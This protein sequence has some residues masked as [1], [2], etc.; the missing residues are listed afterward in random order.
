MSPET[1]VPAQPRHSGPPLVSV[2]VPA[3]NEEASLGPCLRSITSQGGV[4]FEIIVVDDQSTDATR[5]IA[6]SFA[7]VQ[8]VSTGEL[9]A[10]WSGKCHAVWTGAQRA[11]GLW[12]L[13]TDADTVHLPGSLAR[14][15]Q[16]AQREGVA[17]LSYS[18]EQQ[19]RG[20]LQWAVMPAIFAELASNYPPRRVCDPASPVAA[21]NGQ[22][23]LIARAAYHTVGGHAAVASSLL[24]DL[25][26]AKLVKQSG[27][28]IRLRHGN[29]LVRTRMYRDRR[30]LVEGWTKNLALLFPR[31]LRLATFRLAEC[32]VIV[33]G[34]AAAIWAAGH[35]VELLADARTRELVLAV[36]GLGAL[37]WLRVVKR[38]RR[39]HFGPLA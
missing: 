12:L 9:P 25:E 10:G 30:S 24:E 27:S 11:R 21:A 2:I 31:T 38:V 19:V 8:V 4:D 20:L 16:E 32:V 39:A 28:R 17:L 3:R 15:L 7:G 26:L 29:G 36:V 14:S 37:S 33:A 35:R 5:Q 22:Y 1:P 23:L 13:F 18:P 34:I 6:E